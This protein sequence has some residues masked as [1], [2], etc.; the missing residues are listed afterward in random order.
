MRVE[1]TLRARGP[2]FR[3]GSDGQ[4]RTPV[5][6]RILLVVFLV[7]NTAWAAAVPT[8]LRCE[9]RTEPLGMDNPRPRLSWILPH[10]MARQTGY[11]ILVAT[12]VELLAKDSGDLWDSGKV[13]SDQSVGVEYAGQPLCSHA[14]CEWKVRVWDANGKPSPWSAPAS[15]T[16]GILRPE[17]W[18]AQWISTEA[19]P[20]PSVPGGKLTILKATYAAFDGKASADVTAHVAKLVKDD[21]LNI[22][23][24]P[25]ILGGDPSLWH[26]KELRVVYEFN[27]KQHEAAAEDFNNLRLPESR[28]L[29]PGPLDEPYVR[30]TFNVEDLPDS[31]LATVNVLGFYELY[32]NGRKVGNDVLSPALSNYHKRSLY[33]TYDLKPYLQKGRNCIGL[34]LSRGWYWK[35]LDGRRNPAVNHDTAIARLQL[36]MSVKGKA[37]RIGTGPAWLCKSSG[38]QIIGPW[39]WSNMGGELVDARRDD[40]HWTDPDRDDSDW[41]PARVVSAPAIPADA[42]KCP[43]MCVLKRLPAVARTMLEKDAGGGAKY[44]LDFGTNLTGWLKLRLH[45]LHAGQ[46][47][48]IRYADKKNPYQTF[49]QSDVF[50]SAGN[51]DEE[52]CSKFN[53]HG[54][55]YAVIEGLPAAP[56]L[57]D[58]EALLV[59]ADWETCGGFACSSPLLNRMHDVNLWTLRCLSQSGYMSDCPHRERLGYGDGQVSIESCIMNFRMAPFY[60][61]WATDW[62]DGAEPDGYL[63][64]TAPHYKSGGGGPAWGGCAQALVWRNYLYYADKRIIERN[65]DACRRHVEAIEAHAQEGVVRAFGGQWDFI[66]DW[67]PPGRGMDT[68]NWPPPP[69]AELFNN[70]YRLYL[71]E[72]LAEMADILGR[73][74]DAKACRAELARLRPLVHKAFYDQDRQLYVLDEQSYQLMP[75]MT[76]VAPAELRDTVLKKL[77][78]GIRVNHKDHLDTGMLGTYFLLNYLSQIG[79]DDLAFAIVNQRTYPGWGY[80]LEQGATTWWEQWNGYY[81]HIHS[82]FTSLDGWFYQGLAGIRPDPARPGFKRIIIK[83][84]IVGDLTWVKAHFDSPYGRIVSN[85]RRDGR[86]LTMDIAIPANTTA[87]LYVPT[88]RP[89]EVTESGRPAAEAAGVTFLRAEKGAAIYELDFGN[90]VFEA[91]FTD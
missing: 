44:E 54:F 59:G 3:G 90:R 18:Q 27:G 6:Q 36:D 37:L 31:A 46:S 82:C 14:R 9:Y 64:H 60:E 81:S 10:S 76:G 13:D 83:P 40:L 29:A 75:L 84:A 34:W 58:A 5:I 8:D 85:W 57:T 2:S 65:Y 20:P 50:I 78:Y 67:V 62:C 42:Q 88:S 32:V 63:P 52:F 87:T 23:V 33:L 12:S 51:A 26:A 66:G 49:E 79:R 74:E 24:D 39:S 25:K 86:R 15:W 28:G 55:R 22:K 1:S 91:P 38:R 43:T 72:Q 11:Q 4:K 41:F 45:G 56:A 53:Y 71:R 68:N 19:A 89:G 21:R 7:T 80:M 35:V 69:A 77:E 30:H 16:M 70:C 48:H 73:S 17:D 61:K 47:I